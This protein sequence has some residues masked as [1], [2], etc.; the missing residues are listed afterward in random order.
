MYA[1]PRVVVLFGSTSCHPCHAAKAWW[2]KQTAPAGWTF[3]YWEWK[4][5]QDPDDHEDQGVITRSFSPHLPR[6]RSYPIVSV[7]ENARPGAPIKDVVSWA[8]GGAP[9]ATDGL[10]PWLLEHPRGLKP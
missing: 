6:N 1:H 4:D 2:E 9:N 10:R 7:I 3:G 8:E 5:E